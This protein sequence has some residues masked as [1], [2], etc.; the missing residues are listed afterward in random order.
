MFA[1]IRSFAQLVG[2]QTQGRE[3]TDTIASSVSNC[4]SQDVRNTIGDQVLLC[5]DGNQA[6]RW[7]TPHLPFPGP[8]LETRIGENFASLM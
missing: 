4:S 6:G 1:S 5:G 2:F 7:D 3:A 8:S